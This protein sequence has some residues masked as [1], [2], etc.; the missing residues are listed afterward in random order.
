MTFTDPNMVTTV[1]SAGTEQELAHGV[2]RASKIRRAFAACSTSE[3][4]V[5]EFFS[6]FDCTNS[7]SSSGWG[8]TIVL[9]TLYERKVFVQLAAARSRDQMP[10]KVHSPDTHS[11][12]RW[13]GH[14]GVDMLSSL[15]ENFIVVLQLSLDTPRP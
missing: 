6:V 12:A 4:T 3:I 10:G 14:F 8:L 1:L 11:D 13:H 5:L 7:E 9:L 2:L 15:P